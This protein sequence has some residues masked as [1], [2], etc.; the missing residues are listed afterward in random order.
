MCAVAISAVGDTESGV[1]CRIILPP[2]CLENREA[3]RVRLAVRSLINNPVTIPAVVSTY[4]VVNCDVT[5]R[6]MFIK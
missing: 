4:I 5:Q 1:I 2:W 6:M 3:D